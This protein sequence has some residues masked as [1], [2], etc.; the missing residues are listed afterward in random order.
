MDNLNVV[1]QLFIILYYNII[2]N[3][4]SKQLHNNVHNIIINIYLFF[5]F[6]FLNFQCRN[7]IIVN[8]VKI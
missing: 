8:L 1:H 5:N 2:Y 7:A 3:N 4:D 6:F